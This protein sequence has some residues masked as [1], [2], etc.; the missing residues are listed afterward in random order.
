MFLK[1]CLGC[2]GYLPAAFHPN[3]N[4]SFLS[5]MPK[6]DNCCQEGDPQICCSHDM[7]SGPNKCGPGAEVWV[8]QRSEQDWRWRWHSHISTKASNQPITTLGLKKLLIRLVQPDA[9]QYRWRHFC[10]KLIITDP[11]FHSCWATRGLI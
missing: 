8:G 4:K 5:L 3:L 10:Y 6:G 9:S 7:L 1:N 2:F 11:N